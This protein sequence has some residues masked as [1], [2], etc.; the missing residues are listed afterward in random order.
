MDVFS[1]LLE[2]KK[3]TLH[4]WDLYVD[5]NEKVNFVSVIMI[6]WCCFFLSVS[7]IWVS[8]SEL[9]FVPALFIQPFCDIH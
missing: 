9:I 7:G 6:L 8:L 4:F 1:K 3:A 2:K 5:L